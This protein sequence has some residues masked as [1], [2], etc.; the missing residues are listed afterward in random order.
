MNR[1]VDCA[2]GRL[3]REAATTFQFTLL[4]PCSRDHQVATYTPG[5]GTWRKLPE[6]ATDFIAALNPE[7]RT[8]STWSPC[9]NS[10]VLGPTYLPCP[11]QRRKSLFSAFQISLGASHLGARGSGMYSLSR[12][13]ASEVTR[14]SR[15]VMGNADG[16][17][18]LS[19]GQGREGKGREG[20]ER[21]RGEWG[22]AGRE[23]K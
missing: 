12:L 5:L 9:R 15:D 1:I 7:V 23:T 4:Q 16:Q 11:C 18:R 3:F 10:Y 21:K 14:E 6:T 19:V 2:K 8:D 22:E 17:Q 20:R 13:P